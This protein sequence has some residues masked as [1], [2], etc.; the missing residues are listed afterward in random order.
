[1]AGMSSAANPQRFR[2]QRGVTTGVVEEGRIIEATEYLVDSDR[3]YEVYLHQAGGRE[4]VG[5]CS[6]E[7]GPAGS[8]VV[9]PGFA[10]NFDASECEFSGVWDTDHA[11]TA[12]LKHVWMTVEGA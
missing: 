11:G 3:E 8:Y 1:M 10:I 7:S 6:I 12:R 4:L 9:A 5:T 2:L